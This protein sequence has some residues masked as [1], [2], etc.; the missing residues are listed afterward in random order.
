M[1]LFVKDDVSILYIH[2]PKTGGSTIEH[3]FLAN[4]FRSEFLDDRSPSFNAYRRCSP[5]HLHAA[6]LLLLLRPASI[7]YVFMTV[8]HPL[9]RIVSEY[10]MERRIGRRGRSLRHWLDRSLAA[11]MDD[12]FAGDN[13]FRPQ[14]E[15][16]IPGCDVFRQENGFGQVFVER[17][18]ERTGVAFAEGEMAN[19]NV[20]GGQGVD[21]AEIEKI[22]S[23]VRQFYRLDFATFGYRPTP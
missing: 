8:R 20:D 5:Q 11:Y 10:K 7:R 16:V 4:G 15:F 6:P 23:T 1:P 18:S 3:F 17:L 22:R 21:E 9:S 13:H 12:P 2:V 14:H 19:H